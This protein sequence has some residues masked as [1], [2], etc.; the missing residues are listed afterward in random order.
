MGTLWLLEAGL[1]RIFLNI[2]GA[3]PAVSGPMAGVSHLFILCVWLAT[4]KVVFGKA[5][6][7][8]KWCVPLHVVLIFGPTPIALG[9]WWISIAERL[10]SIW[11]PR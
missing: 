5:H 4:E 3:E 8:T 7:V 10:A 1:G 6:V 9:E 11:V 2:V